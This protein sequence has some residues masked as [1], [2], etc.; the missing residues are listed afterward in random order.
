MPRNGYRPVAFPRFDGGLNL[1]DQPDV[2]D[3]SQAIDA[4]NVTFTTRGAVRQRDGYGQL[5]TSPSSNRYDSLQPY[6]K[7]DG[8]K[9]L[10][11]GAG[12][13][14][15]AIDTN[16]ALL[17]SDATPTSSPH[18]FTRFGGPSAERVYIANGSD[19][20][21]YWDGTSFTTPTYEG[22]NPM[23][24]FLAVTGW[25]NR[26][27][28]AR[29]S[30]TSAGHNPSSVIFSEP[31]DPHNFPV[32]SPQFTYVDL[33]PG[34][35]EEIMGMCS[36]REFLFVFKETSFF[37]V[38]GTSVGANGYPVFE[39]RQVKAEAGLASSR[40]LA[41]GREGVYFMDRQGVYVTTG[42][43]PKQISDLIDPIFIHVGSSD[44]YTGGILNDTAIENCAMA[45]KDERV[46]LAFPTG[47]FANDRLLEH[48][49]RYGW[50][51][52][53]DIP[54]AALTA[55]RVGTHE[56]LVFAY[57]TGTNDIGHY[58]P[59][60]ANDDGVAISSHWR[61]G[62]Q[63]YGSTV[64]KTVRESKLWGKGLVEVGISKDFKEPASY[65]SV[66]FDSGLDTWGDGTAG[67]DWADGTDATDL[68]ASDPGIR[69]KLVRASARGTVFSTRFRNTTLDK[70]WRVHRF[71]NHL[72]EQRK[73]STVRTEA[74]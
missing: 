54:A 37:V 70:T 61:S 48:D 58:G 19:S 67:D 56:D 49:P 31:G 8:T 23:G 35:G 9:Q 14:L 33:T 17:A 2:V 32:E 26:L 50:W 71:A 18:F 72:R 12:R 40:G 34:D 5:T 43:E 21:K 27:V 60:F 36:W 64:V 29:I 39:Y 47:S 59:E 73:P 52:L 16:G 11:A 7:T 55:F 1:R 3:P 22:T 62:W 68:W 45:W 66:N 38:Y 63:D 10:V 69:P 24:R 74:V 4:L 13:R 15:E 25:D 30:G 51:T 57:S 20:V 41:V 46:Y 42:S 44:F 65:D 53:H 6:Y 28:N